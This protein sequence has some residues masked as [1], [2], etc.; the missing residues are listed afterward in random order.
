M[1][2]NNEFK[3]SKISYLFKSIY[4]VWPIELLLASAESPVTDSFLERHIN[5]WYINQ[6]YTNVFKSLPGESYFN[7]GGDNKFNIGSS[8]IQ[9]LKRF[10]YSTYSLSKVDV[11]SFGIFLS[12]TYTN[13]I[14]H[15]LTLDSNNEEIYTID[16]VEDIALLKSNEK[17]VLDWHNTVIDQI[18]FPFHT[19][20]KAMIDINPQRR[21]NITQAT[22][23]YRRVL[24]RMRKYFIP[25]DLTKYLPP[26]TKGPSNYG[27]ES[28]PIRARSRSR[29]R[30]TGSQAPRP[31]TSPINKSRKR[32]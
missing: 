2:K 17:E 20:I 7:Y 25:A 8:E 13:L 3:G 16:R 27:Y 26:N 5:H 30:T 9:A 32:R 6:R 15:I 21:I 28:P 14:G 31:Y 24:Q 10:D 1:S 23:G 19:V 11:F 22:D 4:P 18:S 12:R 29:N